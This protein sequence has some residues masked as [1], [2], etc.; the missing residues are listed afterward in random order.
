MLFDIIQSSLHLGESIPAG[1]HKLPEGAVKTVCSNENCP[2]VPYQHG[3]CFEKW[4][5]FLADGVKRQQGCYRQQTKAAIQRELW[6]RR[7]APLIVKLST[8]PA[9]H[10]HIR[11][12]IQDERA[13]RVWRQA[14]QVAR[15][16]QP[17]P[18][19]AATHR[20]NRNR[21]R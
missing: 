17:P 1:A 9:C 21:V 15:N 7:M 8:C 5:E 6:D 2:A 16:P 12:A 20:N 18:A 3:A 19:A 4:E 13:E 14:A 11:R 10:G